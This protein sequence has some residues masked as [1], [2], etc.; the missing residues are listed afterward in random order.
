MAMRRMARLAVGEELMRSSPK[1]RRPAT[2]PL[3]MGG[4]DVREGSGVLG[5][6]GR[7]EQVG[8]KEGRV[9]HLALV[10]YASR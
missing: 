2:R 6:R 10:A 5:A 8:A 4:Q 7:W 1:E 3:C 9:E